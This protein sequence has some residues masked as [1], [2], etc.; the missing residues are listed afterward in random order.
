M[1]SKDNK[2][3]VDY[4]QK[5]LKKQVVVFIADIL[6]AKS[7]PKKIVNILFSGNVSNRINGVYAFRKG[8]I[9]Q[10]DIIGTI[11]SKN[12]FCYNVKDQKFIDQLL[13]EN[14]KIIKK[15]NK[16]QKEIRILKVQANNLRNI[17][18]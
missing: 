15:Y 7:T 14:Q 4:I 13:K 18:K 11:K 3:L 6:H 16:L 10:T 17:T 12:T 9:A 5:L 1:V 8:I 2:L